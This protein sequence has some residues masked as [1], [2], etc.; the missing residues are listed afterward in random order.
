L[1]VADAWQLAVDVHA[2]FD[3][4]IDVAQLVLLAVLAVSHARG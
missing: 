1:S 2:H 3:F 4:G